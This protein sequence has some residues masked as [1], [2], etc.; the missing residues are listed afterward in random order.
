MLEVTRMFDNMDEL[1]ET[2]FSQADEL[3]NKLKEDK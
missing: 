1:V 2:F 3:L